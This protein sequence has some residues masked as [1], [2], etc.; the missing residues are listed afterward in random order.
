MDEK[1]E[2]FLESS[3]TAWNNIYRGAVKPI[4]I[5]IFVDPA[6]GV[7]DLGKNLAPCGGECQSASNPF[8]QY[9]WC[10]KHLKNEG[11]LINL[12]ANNSWCWLSGEV[13]K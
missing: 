4:N 2:R 11:V 6:G 13:I 9:F 5:S 3:S 1:L 10:E 7:W 12:H 8:R